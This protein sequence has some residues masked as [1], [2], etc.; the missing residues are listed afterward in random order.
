VGVSRRLRWGGGGGFKKGRG[1]GS[2]MGIPPD[3]E[4]HIIYVK[5][6][7]IANH[8]NHRKTGATTWC[9]CMSQNTTKPFPARRSRW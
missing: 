4:L 9:A 1:I 3:Q 2:R 7:T 8:R 5:A 6:A